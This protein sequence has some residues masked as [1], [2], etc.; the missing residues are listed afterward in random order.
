M[1]TAEGRKQ[2]RAGFWKKAVTVILNTA[3]LFIVY[4]FAVKAGERYF[5]IVPYKVCTVVYSA[6]LVI[7][8]VVYFLIKIRS[9]RSGN[10]GGSKAAEGILLWIIPLFAVLIY[11]FFDL[12]LLDSVKSA[13]SGLLS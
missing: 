2:A 10:D 3:A 13:L 8:S 9:V 4:V 7:L 11:D 1:D 6:A 12:Y 5:T